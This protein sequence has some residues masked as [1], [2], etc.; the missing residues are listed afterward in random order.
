M[1][2]T[3]AEQLGEPLPGG[4]EALDDE[5]KRLIGDLLRAARRRQAAALTTAAEESLEYV[6]FLLRGAVRKAVG[7]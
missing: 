7:L 5:Q 2:R 4:I 1:R 3:L 6:P